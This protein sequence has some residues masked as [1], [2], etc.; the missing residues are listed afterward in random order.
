MMMTRGTAGLMDKVVCRQLGVGIVVSAAV[1]GKQSK[2]SNALS[3][4]ELVP[5]AVRLH[6]LLLHV[7]KKPSLMKA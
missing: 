4:E 5:P 3:L 6:H 2:A 7:K 1:P